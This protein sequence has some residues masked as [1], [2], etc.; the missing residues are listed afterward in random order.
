MDCV[1]FVGFDVETRPPMFP[2]DAPPAV[3][4]SLVDS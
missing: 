2:V 4:C 3:D 1:G